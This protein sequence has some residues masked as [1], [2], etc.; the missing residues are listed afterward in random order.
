MVE[1]LVFKCAHKGF[2]RELPSDDFPVCVEAS[3]VE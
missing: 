2:C 1:N 3:E